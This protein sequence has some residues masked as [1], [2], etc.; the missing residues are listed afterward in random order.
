MKEWN[1]SVNPEIYD[2]ALESSMFEYDSGNMKMNTDL[3]LNNNKITNLSDGFYANDAVNVG[4]IE[5]IKLILDPLLFFIKNRI[6]TII[7]P[8]FFYD[9]KEPLLMEILP[10][11]IIGIVSVKNPI[12][13]NLLFSSSSQGGGLTINSLDQIKGLQFDRNME[14]LLHLGKNVTHLSPFTILISM[15]LNDKITLHFSNSTN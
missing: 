1:D 6:Y 5:E 4:Q 3:D 10:P 7:F 9:L 14:I 8:Y 2:H 13:A 15:T 12:Q 11:N